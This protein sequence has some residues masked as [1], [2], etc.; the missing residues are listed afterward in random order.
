MDE[1]GEMFSAELDAHGDAAES[2]LVLALVSLYAANNVP[3]EEQ[4]Q[5]AISG[6]IVP[7]VLAILILL[8]V[9]LSGETGP[10]PVDF[11]Q[12]ADEMSSEA[13]ELLKQELSNLTVEVNRDPNTRGFEG[14]DFRARMNALVAATL[15]SVTSRV[16]QRVAQVLGYTHKGWRTRLDTKVRLS[17]QSLEGQIVPMNSLFKDYLGVTLEYPGDRSAP[18]EAWIS[19]RCRLS[20]ARLRSVA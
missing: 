3:S 17:H 15:T 12:L 13:A 20:F 7:Y 19:C 1:T 8:A 10:E 11:Y 2:A 14:N 9:S 4:I 6:V 16:L 5:N 18:I